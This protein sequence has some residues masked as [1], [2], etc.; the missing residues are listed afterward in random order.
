MSRNHYI[1]YIIDKSRKS[2]DDIVDKVYKYIL[3][4]IEDDE[5]DDHDLDINNTKRVHKLKYIKENIE[6]LESDQI[7][8]IKNMIM[9]ELDNDQKY[10]IALE[11]TNTLLEKIGR[12]KILDLCDFKLVD[13]DSLL[14]NDC[15]Q[16]IFDKLDYIFE[17]GFD[18]K[19]CKYNDRHRIKHYHISV[20]KGIINQLGYSLKTT[21]RNKNTDGKV[22]WYSLYTISKNE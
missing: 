20:L 6:L 8:E 3:S 1:K 4:L 2:S 17:H 13:R 19:I 21:Y 15:K 14:S 11:L 18:K 12:K 9:A 7:N 16:Y 10:N 5:D 22:D